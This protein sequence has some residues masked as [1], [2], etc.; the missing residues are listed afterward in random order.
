VELQRS[1]R[2]VRRRGLGVAAIGSDSRDVLR[3]FAIQHGITYPI[4][5]DPD[6]AVFKRYGLIAAAPT[7]RGV[8]ESFLYPATIILSEKG[9]VTA[10]FF[11]QPYQIV[12]TVASQ[13]AGTGRA[14]DVETGWTSETSHVKI[15]TSV[16]DVVVSAGTRF[17]LLVDVLPKRRI[18]VFAPGSEGARGIAVRLEPDDRFV[19]REPI[20]PQP[21]RHLFQ[22]LGEW[23]S[24]FNQ[25]FRIVLDIVATPSLA[26]RFHPNV[27]GGTITIRGQVDYQACDDRVCYPPASV[28][29]CWSLRLDR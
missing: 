19:A 22:P 29:V 3:A 8:G 25:P 12:H 6:L 10:R 23:Q 13:L 15:L 20:Y 17:S 16:S 5:S 11:E 7:G 4:L 21:I 18:H 14:G 28:S 26:A 1:L 27:D 24:V 2:H 9:D